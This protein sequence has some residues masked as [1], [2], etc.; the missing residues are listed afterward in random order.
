MSDLRRPLGRLFLCA[1]ILAAAAAGYGASPVTTTVSDV[2]YRADGTPA[3]GTLLISWPAFVS[4]DSQAVSAGSLSVPIGPGGAINLALVPNEGA[5]PGGTYYSV[6]VKL[7]GG[8]TDKEFWTV[9]ATSPTTIAK[10]RSMVVPQSVAVQVASKEY[11]DS[12]VS[13]KADDKAVVHS[14]GGE[15]ITGVKQFAMSPRVPGPVA[16]EDVANK[17]YVDTAVGQVGEGSYVKKA[18][19]AMTGP[20]T[21]SGDPV[22]S[23]QAATRHYVDDQVSGI[24]GALNT[25]ESIANKDQANGYA[26]LDTSGFVGNAHL[27]AGATDGAKCLK[28]DHSWG[29]C[30]S[31][32]DSSTS[33]RYVTSDYNWTVSPNTPTSL[34]AGP[35]TVTITPCPKGVDPTTTTNNY[36]YIAGTGTPEAVLVTGGTAC[37]SNHLTLTFTASGSHSTGYTV[38]SASS[39]IRE[40]LTDARFRPTNPSGTW[41]SGKVIVPPGEYKAYAPIYIQASNQTVDFSGS[42]VECYDATKACIYVGTPLNSGTYQNITVVNPKG[43]PMVASGTNPFVEVN[44]QATK[45][46]KPLTRAPL[47]GNTFGYL[48]QVDD[49]QAFE[50]EGIDPSSGDALRCDAGFCGSAVYAPGPFA[51][52][53]AVGWIHHSNMTLNCR[54]N[55]IEWQ[56]G[57]S[58]KVSDSI[59]QGYSQ[60][61]IRG[62]RRGGYGGLVLDNVYT[63][64]GAQQSQ[65]AYLQ[66]KD[67]ADTV[68]GLMRTHDVALW[69][70][71]DTS[72]SSPTTAQY[73]GAIGQIEAGGS[74]ATIQT[75]DSIVDG[76]KAKIAEMVAN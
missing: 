13:Q 56:S 29:S 44:A 7:D 58:L 15:T 53:A 21:L 27:G 61:G 25:K 10:I 8:T 11:V 2:I 20:L 60:F 48:V 63:E 59:V 42:I 71:N 65:F 69:N 54:S 14:A 47:T 36:V 18:G 49:D 6:V 72:L 73:F 64:V 74:A 30:G 62:G 76:L 67:L 5:S 1:A 55:G 51:G 34:S 24:S 4:A 23:N 68:E 52:N 35:N 38:G 26:G 40:A 33:I 3:K 57:N 28:G 39:G 9:P 41:Q 45:I 46:V 17:E 12:R 43:R 32:G 70:G 31:G 22:S 50:L 16:A 66:A 37:S 19:D 75:T